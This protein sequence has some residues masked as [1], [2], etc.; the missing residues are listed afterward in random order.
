[1]E[2]NN[3][4]KLVKVI[5]SNI[6][7]KID[8]H[9]N[10]RINAKSCLIL[11]PNMSFGFKFYL[12]FIMENYPSYDLYLGSNEEISETEFVKIN[13]NIRFVHF[14][15]K[16]KEFINLLDA[17]PTIIILGLKVNQMKSLIKTDDSEEI[18]HIILGSVMANKSVDILINANG[19][20]FNKLT[21]IISEIKNMGIAV[22]NIQQSHI[23]QAIK[24]DLITER[25]IE[26][27]KNKGLKTLILDKKQLITPLA[28]DKLRDLKI[29]IEY[30]EEDK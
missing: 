9:S 29:N 17:I 23:P 4:D 5:T 26:S 24:V 1:M 22:T 6:L 14:D 15:L 18:N 12:D 25:Y 11:I 8:T 27:L 30:I 7:N 13:P 19:L 16:N 21:D 3:L 2:V 20:I 10:F 28:K